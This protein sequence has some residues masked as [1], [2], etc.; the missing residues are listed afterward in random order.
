VAALAARALAGL[1][2]EGQALAVSQDGVTTVTVT[3]VRGGRAAS[4]LAADVSDDALAR[5]ARAATLHARRPRALPAP[6]LPLPS[7]ATARADAA[8][9]M[10]GP[11]PAP[12]PVPAGFTLELAS[13]TAD[14]AVASTAGIE[15]EERRS[16]VVAR[17]TAR[18][19]D[20]AAAVTL[21]G[22]GPVDVDDAVAELRALLGEGE[23]AGPFAPHVPPGRAAAVADEDLGRLVLGP[24]AV[25][26]VLEALRPAF[27]VDAALGGPAPNPVAGTVTLTD[28]A[29]HPGTLR[30]AYDA[31]GVARARV[32]L[33]DR[34]TAVGHVHDAASAHRAGAASTGHAT[35][36]LT[37]APLPENLLL[38]PGAAPNVQALVEEVAHGLFVPALTPGR[39]T[40]G[41]ARIVRGR[42]T[43]AVSPTRLE[44]DPVAILAAADELTAARRLVA[45]RGHC[46]GGRGAATVPALRTAGGIRRAR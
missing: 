14:L 37:L 3:A 39:E 7:P 10:G 36:P 9:A 8:A 20:R 13:I 27:G 19:D 17:V 25:A 41:A 30:R 18:R 4:A 12:P 24:E 26:V 40:A 35:R 28:D 21:A 32:T 23:A 46:P 33:I 2:G 5:A 43:A 11:T 29:A 22:A 44:L 31:E 6:P 15:V 38:D 45:L 34:G 16:H 42:L 1:E